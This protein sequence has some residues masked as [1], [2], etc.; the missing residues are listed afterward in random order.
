MSDPFKE[1]GGMSFTFDRANQLFR[2]TFGD[3]ELKDA[4][5]FD[6]GHNF[7]EH[8]DIFDEMMIG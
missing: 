5:F 6:F 8:K 4:G 3:S 1:F 2:E 7:G